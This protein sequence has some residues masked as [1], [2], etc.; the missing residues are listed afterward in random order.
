VGAWRGDFAA[1][2]R[3]RSGAIA[4][5]VA[6]AA[7]TVLTPDANAAA[8]IGGPFAVDP[9]DSGGIEST[10]VQTSLPAGGLV[11]S[12]IDGV[13]TRWRMRGFTEGASPAQILFRVLKAAGTDTF[14]A[15]SSTSAMLPTSLGTHEFPA[16][17]PIQRGDYIGLTQTAGNTI[18]Q[19]FFGPGVGSFVFISGP[20]ADGQT[21]SG[22]SYSDEVVTMNADVEADADRDGYGDESQDKCPVD[23]ATQGRC[24]IGFAKL[25]RNKNKGTALLTVTVPGAGTV[26]LKGKGVVSQRALADYRVGRTFS[27]TV[28]GPGQVKFLIKPKGKKRKKLNKTGTVKVK[29]SVTFTPTSGEANTETKR[30]KLVKKLD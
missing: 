19:N 13:V 15:V 16:H 27:K 17:T 23:A 30:V 2:R 8:N 6:F 12:P 29:V 7:L 24:P 1:A 26:S 20:F 14:T 9:N 3:W 18:W 25:K 10:Y 22:I 21:L 11:T 28:S 4:T 5:T